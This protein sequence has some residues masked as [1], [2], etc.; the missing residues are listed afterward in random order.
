M[1]NM[2]GD[3][4]SGIDFSGA[5]SNL[6][7]WVGYGVL[8]LFILA[9]FGSVYYFMSFPMK[10]NVYPLFGSGK[11]GV[12]SV[13]KYKSNR[14][15]WIKDHSAWYA[16]WPLFNKKNIEPFDDEFIYPGKQLYAFDL[17]GRWFPG[18]ININKTEETIR[19]EINPVPYWVRN[20]QALEYKENA[21]EF[22]KQDFWTQN[23]AFIWMLLSV[24]ICCALCG[25]TIYLS[26]K[27]AAGGTDAMK[28][29]TNAITGITSSGIA[30]PG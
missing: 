14:V 10:A 29:L 19:A 24:A 13:G 26:Y 9:V 12:F 22:A 16:L 18:R 21:L 23:K 3:A 2:L 17:N 28:G 1:A 25:V 4:F 7:Y 27:Y 6:M 5:I 8:I 11:D 30:P 15:K 20:W